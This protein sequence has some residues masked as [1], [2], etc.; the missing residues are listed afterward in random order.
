[1]FSETVKTARTLHK[2]AW[3]G[4]FHRT[5]TEDFTEGGPSQRGHVR[6]RLPKVSLKNPLKVFARRKPPHTHSAHSNSACMSAV[7][8]ASPGN[9]GGYRVLL[10]HHIDGLRGVEGRVALAA[11]PGLGDE[12]LLEMIGEAEV[13]HHQTT[14]LVAEDAVHPG[15]AGCGGI[16]SWS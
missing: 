12:R 9:S 13:I 4:H 1:M 8:T 7:F 16:Q 5:A 14:G 2:P 3:T 15:D 11:A 10:L 6:D